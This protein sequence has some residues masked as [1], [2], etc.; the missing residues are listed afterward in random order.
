MQKGIN[1]FL[2]EAEEPPQHLVYEQAAASNPFLMDFVAT[3]APEQQY[4]P[5]NPFLA[6]SMDAVIQ[7]PPPVYSNPF[8]D[9]VDT[10]L[11][12]PADMWSVP[13]SEPPVNLPPAE[14]FPSYGSVM[15]PSTKDLLDAVTG[16]LDAT[17]DSLLDRL[18]VSQPSPIP[19]PPSPTPSPRTP[20][21][22]TPDL[23]GG[24]DDEVP[25]PKPGNVVEEETSIPQV[26]PVAEPEPPLTKPSVD[27]M[28]IGRAHV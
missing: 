27:I 10:N 19:Q 28:E 23:L 20:S 11:V 15:P 22:V 13:A 4:I 26:V 7:Q 3:S 25:I 6:Q 21:P 14:A 24:F 1:P 8:A 12:Q 17:S 16:S 18:R 9:I 2:F 5:E